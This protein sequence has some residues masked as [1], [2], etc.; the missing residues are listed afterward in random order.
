MLKYP[1]NNANFAEVLLNW[2]W[3]PNNKY[4]FGLDAITFG[5]GAPQNVIKSRPK[6]LA[7]KITKFDACPGPSVLL[8]DTLPIKP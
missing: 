6:W 7:L 2:P 1:G 8:S 3:C 5:L 4:D